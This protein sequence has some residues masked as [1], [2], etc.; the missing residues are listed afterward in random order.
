MATRCLG[1]GRTQVYAQIAC[2]DVNN[3]GRLNDADAANPA[4]LPD[5]NGDGRHDEAD[6]AF[7]RG[8]DIS[9]DPAGKRIACAHENKDVGPDWSVFEP[10]TRHLSCDGDKKAVLILGIGGGVTNLRQNDAAGV[11][12]VIEDLQTAFEKKGVETVTVL[13]GQAVN[14]AA[15]VN[16]AMELWVAHATQVLLDAHPC[17]RVAMIGHSHGAIVADVAAAK[18]EATYADRFV[19]V[20]DLDRVEPLY[21]GDTHTWPESVPIFNIY[22]TSDTRLHGVARDASN[23]N[24]WDATGEKGPRNG[25]KGGPLTPV[26][27]TTIDNSDSV[28][29]RIVDD[30]VGHWK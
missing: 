12:R 25:D 26:D 3:D 21:S 23:V 8:I 20:V 2:A 27:H 28:R 4:Q 1:G 10:G 15:S 7:V 17:L 29:K 18:L 14:S 11:K 6:A 22:E 16:S 13:S 5:F 9:L 24:N 19:E 30:V